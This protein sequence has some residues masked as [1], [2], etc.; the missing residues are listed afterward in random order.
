M[1]VIDSQRQLVSYAMAKLI[2]LIIQRRKKSVKK[3]NLPTARLVSIFLLAASWLLLLMQLAI[4]WKRG[5]A[6]GSGRLEYTEGG[7]RLGSGV[8]CAEYFRTSST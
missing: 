4:L 1:R 3:S 6:K 7:R 8:A 2:R 5:P